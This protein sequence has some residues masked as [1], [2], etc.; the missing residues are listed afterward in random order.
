MM[1]AADRQILAFS[2]RLLI[3]GLEN[4][5][6]GY[7]YP[8]SGKYTELKPLYFNSDLGRIGIFGSGPDTIN[9]P[10]MLT[11][12]LGGD[13]CYYNNCA[14]AD[15]LT[16]PLS[17]A[18][19]FEGNDKYG[20]A[21]KPARICSSQF[22]LSILLDRNGNDYYYGGS[23]SNAFTFGGFSLLLDE[24]G[25]DT[26]VC[27]NFGIGSAFHGYSALI[28]KKGKDSY[29]SGSYAQGFGS[30]GGVGLLLESEGNDSIIS[31]TGSFCQGASKGR[32]ADAGD[33][34]SLGGGYGILVNTSGDDIYRSLSFSQGASYY[35]GMGI[36]SDL[37]GKDTYDAESHSQ[38]A[39]IH[40]TTAAFTDIKGNDVYNKNIPAN[41]LTQ[42]TGYARDNSYSFFMELSGD[43]EYHFGNK[44]FGVGDIEAIGSS[45]DMEGDDKYFWH[46]NGI[47]DGFGSFGRAQGLEGT[48]MSVAKYPLPDRINTT[49]GIAID[50]QGADMYRLVVGNDSSRTF[51]KDRT[52]KKILDKG[53][54]SIRSDLN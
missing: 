48:A 22:G 44:S 18:I 52:D 36:L 38:G 19:D 26:Y 35:H 41:K 50:G 23:Y 3:M 46:R 40:F 27:D 11:I 1:K 16:R 39:A 53:Y 28:D 45:A 42:I 2:S 4:I 30:T 14:T 33:G 32:W 24:N 34:F 7:T 12:D 37:S 5:I 8:G 13:D 31:E 17:L 20:R 15:W 9:Q 49:A 21:D 47:Y 51:F 10:C 29:L 54:I 6:A 25:D 43:D